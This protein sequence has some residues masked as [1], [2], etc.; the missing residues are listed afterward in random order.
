ML[1]CSN[2]TVRRI[3]KKEKKNRTEQTHRVR[4]KKKLEEETD[5]E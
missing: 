1:T 2:W 5:E 4:I 3:K